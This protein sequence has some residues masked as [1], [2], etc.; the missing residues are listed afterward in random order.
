MDPTTA[1]SLDITDHAFTPASDD[2]LD[3]GDVGAGT[4]PASRPVPEGAH[5][6]APSQLDEYE[7]GSA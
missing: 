1:P 6:W 5:P 2:I 4:S 7:R 3:L